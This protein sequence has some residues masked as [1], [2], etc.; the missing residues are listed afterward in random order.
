MYCY[1]PSE[2]HGIFRS[3]AAA[4]LDAWHLSQD[5]AA[6]PTLNESFIREDVPMNRILAVN[7]EPEFLFD[8]YFSL[9]CARPMPIYGV[10]GMIDHF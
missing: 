9:H 10:P 2:I 1:K 5:F 3:S 8:G 6:A 7:D 4:P